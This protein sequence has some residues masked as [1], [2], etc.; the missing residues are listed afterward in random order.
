MGSNLDTLVNIGLEKFPPDY[1]LAQQVC[2]AITSISDRRKVSGLVPLQLTRI[3]EKPHFPHHMSSFRLFYPPSSPQP[4]LGKRQPPFRLPQ[5]HRLFKQ[6]QEMVVKGEYSPGPEQ[7]WVCGQPQTTS[8]SSW[9]GFVL[10]DPFWIPFKEVAVSLVYQLAEGPEVICA[11]MLRD[12]AKQALEKLEERTPAQED[13][14][15]CPEGRRCRAPL[16]AATFLLSL[17]EQKPLPPL[18]PSYSI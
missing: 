15:K 16:A 6:L 2:Q 5:E 12:C 1:R 11:Q 17:L 13:P 3:G 14:S 8:P 9:P 4:S 18:L 7:S 10:R